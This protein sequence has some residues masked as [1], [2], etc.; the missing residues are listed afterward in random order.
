MWLLLRWS[1]LM[2]AVPIVKVLSSRLLLHMLE[3]MAAG[4]L[5]AGDRKAAS[6]STIQ[7]GYIRMRDM[8]EKMAAGV[9]EA[10]ADV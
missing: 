2:V 8:L 3:K 10:G 5:E 4:V 7:N 9:L 1:I 6:T